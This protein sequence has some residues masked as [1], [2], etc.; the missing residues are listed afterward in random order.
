MITLI[1][2]CIPIEDRFHTNIYQVKSTETSKVTIRN[3]T[4]VNNPESV[5]IALRKHCVALIETLACF[6]RYTERDPDYLA[7]ISKPLADPPVV[8]N[9]YPRNYR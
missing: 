4:T 8:D 6:N 7:T 3:I 5:V 9:W 1:V 2:Y